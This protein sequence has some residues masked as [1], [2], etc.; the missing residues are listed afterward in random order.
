[1]P[2]QQN[3]PRITP[4]HI[5][6]PEQGEVDLEELGVEA[7]DEPPDEP[8]PERSSGQPNWDLMAR[9]SYR[10][11]T[12]Y[13]DTNYRQQWEDS[14]RAFNNLHPSDSKYNM[15]VYRK[16]S[17]SFVPK[18][19]AVIRKN[20]AAAAAAFF[21]NLDTVSIQASNQDDPRQRVSA[22]VMFQILQYRLTH[23]IPWFQVLV[24]GLQDAQTQ[25]A[26]IGHIHWQFVA[27]GKDETLKVVEDKPAVDLVPIENM[28]FHPAANWTDPLHTSPYLIHLIPMYVGDVKE[29]M[30]RPDPKGRTWHQWSDA[31]L[32][33]YTDNANDSTRAARQ[34]LAE[35]PTQARSRITDYDI[36]WVHR[37]IHR[38]RGK[39]YEWYTLASEVRLT[40]PEPL[41]NTVFHGRRPYE[42][43][44]A[45]LETHKAM[46]SSIPALVR[47]PQEDL[48]DTRN[49]RNDNVKFV[50]NKRYLVKRGANVDLQSLVRNVPGGITQVNNVEGEVKELAWPDVTQSSYL[51]EDRSVGSFDE[52]VGNFNPMQVSQQRT[53]RESERT[54]LAIQSPANLLTEYMLK[55]YVETFVLPVLRQLVMLEQHYE[56]DQAV[57][58][59][60]GDK[61]QVREKFGV[62]QVTDDLLEAE[63]TT[64]VNVGMGATDPAMKLQRFVFGMG[65]L[66]RIAVK[67]PPGINLTEVYKEVFALSGYQDGTRFLSNKDPEKVKLEQQ[68][69]QAMKLIQ[70]LHQKVGD[71]S[72]S[73]IVRLQTAREAN[74]SR[75]RIASM[76]TASDSLKQGRDHKQAR[77]LALAG[78][79]MDLDRAQNAPPQIAPLQT[80]GAQPM[81]LGAA[82][83]A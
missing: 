33:R 69:M 23:T 22:A 27:S 19:R 5:A 42:M 31:V 79:L 83:G 9:D 41:A 66:A 7:D 49:Q 58:A 26:C 77:V 73:N 59:L 70:Q 80:N 53:P 29:R 62:G 21:S 40:D 65:N 6:D 28:R 43:G 78:H 45:V 32:R 72:G 44:R 68:L 46:P 12:S 75:E 36:V 13:V 3:D 2:W 82:N 63:L 11:S 39:D 17:H 24:G 38:L 14:I 25:G 81:T 34:G 35:D 47:G 76:R 54:M 48:N 61:A 37:H 51:E 71:R 55:T 8:T 56:T 52:L 15:D 60:A 1:M 10:D 4:P 57:L 67:P 20:E 16:R 50:L 18:T 64:N 30:T 74:Q